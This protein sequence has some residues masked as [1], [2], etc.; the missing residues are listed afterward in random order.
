[1]RRNSDY[2]A[3][4]GGGGVN[5]YISRE[6]ILNTPSVRQYVHIHTGESKP[7]DW[8]IMGCDI[9]DFPAADVQPIV[10][11]NWEPGVAFCPVCGEDKFKNLDADIWADWQPN[12]CPNCGADMRG[13][14]ND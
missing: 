10:R 11:G 4:T 12:F 14:C 6:K 5:D 9:R 8:A 2:V 13:K 3:Q 7:E 1:M